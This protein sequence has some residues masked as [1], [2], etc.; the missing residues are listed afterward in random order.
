M[1]NQKLKSA[2]AIAVNLGVSEA[3]IDQSLIAGANLL[4]SICDGRLTTGAAAEQASDAVAQA[5]SG[6]AALREARES[7]VACHQALTVVRDD[8]G[9]GEA[10]VGCTGNKPRARRAKPI[11]AAVA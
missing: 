4:I 6:L 9:L 3:S 11:L 8:H 1:P 5:V 7:F 2:R 10:D